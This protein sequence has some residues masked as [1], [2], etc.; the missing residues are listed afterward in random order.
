ML[1]DGQGTDKT[2]H[3]LQNGAQNR[4]KRTDPIPMDPVNGIL[5]KWRHSK[6]WDHRQLLFRFQ[7]VVQGHFLMYWIGV[8]LTVDC[9][10]KEA[11]ELFP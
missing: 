1:P 10:L 3:N 4:D 7:K 8:S 11:G 2:I 6:K 5:P 9:L